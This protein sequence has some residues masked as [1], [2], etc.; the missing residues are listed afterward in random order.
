M[1]TVTSTIV[2]PAGHPDVLEDEIMAFALQ[3]EE[4]A[5]YG[6]NE[7]GKFPAESPPDNAMAF[8]SFQAEL[9]SHLTFLKDLKLAHSIAHAV[10]TDASAIAELAGT[11]EQAHDDRH[12]ALQLSGFFEE[13]DGSSFSGEDA[14]GPSNSRWMTTTTAAARAIDRSATSIEDT[15]PT[16]Y[17]QQQ[18]HALTN[19]AQEIQCCVCFEDYRA[20]SIVSLSC[21]DEYCLACLK[22]LFLRAT[23]NENLFPPRCCRQQI[24][25]AL[26]ANELTRPQLNAFRNAEKEYN[27]SNRVYCSNIECGA[28]V[29]TEDIVVDKAYCTQCDHETC[30]TCKKA[31]HQGMD[32]PDDPA[33]QKILSLADTERWQRCYSCAQLVEL[34]HGCNHMT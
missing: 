18:A 33:L 15:T 24:D 17:A 1:A 27:T 13:D 19:L 25:V 29:P 10:G 7:K 30:A 20:F 9:S 21:R 32:C 5:I 4:V 26:I 22:E 16:D 28:F 3:L 31:F 6:Q 12:F 23:G 14:G 8:N 2:A 34:D 11:E